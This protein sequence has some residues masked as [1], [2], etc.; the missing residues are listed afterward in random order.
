MTFDQWVNSLVPEDRAAVTGL[1]DQLGS[2]NS[3]LDSRNQAVDKLITNFPNVMKQ[4][5]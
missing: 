2:I 5:L 3:N 1:R 4:L